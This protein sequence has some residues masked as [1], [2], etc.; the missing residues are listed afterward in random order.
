[1]FLLLILHIVFPTD[2]LKT[3]SIDSVQQKSI[4]FRKSITKQ[5]KT[6][7]YKHSQGFFCDFEDKINAQRKINI[8]LG[9]G[10][11]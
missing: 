2:S 10:N 5:T 1:M 4:M 7:K 6:I 9:I 8:N 11:Q 3:V